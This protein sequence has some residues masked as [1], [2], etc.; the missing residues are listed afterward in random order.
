VDKSDEIVVR[1]TS[2]VVRPEPGLHFAP[3]R[4]LGE[5]CG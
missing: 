5:L 2:S 3:L 4:I 1:S